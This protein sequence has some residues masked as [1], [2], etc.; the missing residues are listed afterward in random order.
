MERI[1]KIIQVKKNKYGMI[2]Y[3]QWCASKNSKIRQKIYDNIENK[4]DE[5][6]NFK[7]ENKFKK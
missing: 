5:E 3:I 2:K 7:I 4:I 6:I 1:W